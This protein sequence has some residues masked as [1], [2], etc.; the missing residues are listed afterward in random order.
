MSSKDFDQLNKFISHVYQRS[1]AIKD[2]FDQAGVKPGDIQSVSDLEKIPVTS[3]DHLVELQEAEPPFG[4]FLAVPLNELQHIFFSPGPLYETHAEDSAVLGSIREVLSIANIQAGDIVINTFGYHLIPTGL[5]CDHMLR[6]IG[7]T[8]IPAGVGN[9]DLQV[10]MMRDLKVNAYIGTPSWLM[11]LIEKINQ[12]GFDFSKDFYLEKVLVSGEPLPPD[13][14]EIFTNQYGLHVTNAY[15]TAELGFLAVNTTGGL[16]MQ[17]LETSIIEILD[18]ES[19]KSVNPGEIGEVVVTTIDR[20]Y[21]LIRLGT[22][23]VA[24]NLDPSPGKSQQKERAMIIVGRIGDAVKVRGMLVHPNQLRHS[25][26]QVPDIVAFQA[27]I[28]RSGHRDSL[29]IKVVLGDMQGDLNAIKE[30]LNQAIKSACRVSVDKVEIV[31]Q[32]D[33]DSEEALIIDQ[34]SWE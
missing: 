23:D 17:L 15:G 13:M 12:S 2:I 1:P 7:A 25:V 5:V 31:G 27:V 30:N 8:V 32:D 29:L 22:G 14:R 20:T 10:K 34:R 9:A 18:P 16:Q 4:G 28:S 3:K 33:L 21:P 11:A 24:M 6:K 26:G 19:G